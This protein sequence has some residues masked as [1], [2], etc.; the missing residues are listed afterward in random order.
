[1]CLVAMTTERQFVRPLFAYVYVRDE[2]DYGKAALQ[3]FIKLDA[4][5]TN[6]LCISFDIFIRDIKL[7]SI[8]LVHLLFERGQQRRHNSLSKGK[9]SFTVFNSMFL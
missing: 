8:D 3:D 1:M 9:L 4:S 7:H 5:K 6:A 2:H